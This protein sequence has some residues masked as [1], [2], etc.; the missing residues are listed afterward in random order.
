MA[1]QENHITGVEEAQR[2]GW[3]ALSAP[4]VVLGWKRLK[5]GNGEGYSVS[6]LM[7]H[8]LGQQP[9]L[10]VVDVLVLG[11]LHPDV[12]SHAI[13]MRSVFP[14]EGKGFRKQHNTKLTQ[15]D[16]GG[17]GGAT[18][19]AQRPATL[20]HNTLAV[21]GLSKDIHE[22]KQALAKAATLSQLMTNRAFSMMTFALC[23]SFKQPPQKNEAC[24]LK[25]NPEVR[26][27][28]AQELQPRLRQISK[29][30]RAILG[31]LEETYIMSAIKEKL[32]TLARDT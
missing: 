4:D 1:Y 26:A 8:L 30:E 28:S 9:G 17:A 20:R 11:V 6:G 2:W 5:D 18:A 32:S 31:A 13:A 10:R 22:N 3:S 23:P 29:T 19:A 14:L 25:L 16:R 15:T 21:P 24:C 27:S 12:P 7:H